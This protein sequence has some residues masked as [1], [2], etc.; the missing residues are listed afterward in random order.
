MNVRRI[1][2][3]HIVSQIG[4]AIMGVGLASAAGFAAGL[5]FLAH[6]MIVKT[7]L[8]F[9]G[10]A[11][12]QVYGTGDLK[13][14]GGM[15]R[16]EPLLAIAWFLGILSLAGIPPLSGFF[17]KLALLQAGVG[18]AEYWIT[19]IAA[20]T[21]IL[22]FFSMLKIWNEVFWKKA[23]TDITALPRVRL[24]LLLPGAALVA[25]SIVMG[26]AAGAVVD[27]SALA[28]GQLAD[29]SAYIR[30]VCGAGGCE[31]VFNTALR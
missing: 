6:V 13:K 19:A 10:G 7:A 31:A 24:G 20:G 22:T 25:A 28:G 29:Q 23:Y 16:R 2:S 8:F 27:Y 18:Q 1:L 3:F 4:Y 11:A 17:G 26:L 15:A 12:E 21:S 30:A 9:I 14:M 5:L